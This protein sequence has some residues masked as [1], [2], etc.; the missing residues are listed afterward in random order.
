MN[1]KERLDKLDSICNRC[2]NCPL[3]QTRK[4]TVFGEGDPDA[5]VMFIGEAPGADEDRQGRPFIGRSGKLLRKMIQAIDIDPWDC[6]IANIM[7]CRPPGNRDP[8]RK[9]IE[10]CV[11]FL[12]KQLE[13]IQPKL[14]VLLG[15]TAVRGLLPEH[16][17]NSV[18]SLRQ[19]SRNLGELSW[20]G[21][22]AIVTYHPSALLQGPKW[23]PLAKD[24]FV[25]LKK[26]IPKLSIS[27]EILKKAVE[28]EPLYA[29]PF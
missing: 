22:P 7:K 28:N 15:K 2:Y 8:E 16:A 29:D 25:F 17:D 13:I 26:E 23:R 10:Q 24:D 27:K 18:M 21:I 5:T 1:K 4:K 20:E 11:K 6:F 9:E 3:G 12:K 19:T 14:L